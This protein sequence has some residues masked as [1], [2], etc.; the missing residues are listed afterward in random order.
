MEVLKIR[1]MSFDV[2]MTKR[3]I[4]AAI[5]TTFTAFEQIPAR[6]HPQAIVDGVVQPFDQRLSLT[7]QRGGGCGLMHSAIINRLGDTGGAD[8]SQAGGT[9][10][11]VRRRT[12]QDR[13]IIHTPAHA[14]TASR[15]I[16]RR[17]AL[18]AGFTHHM[19]LLK[20][21]AA[22]YRVMV[23]RSSASMVRATFCVTVLIFKLCY[24]CS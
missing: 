16:K 13:R 11:V 9:Q 23:Q 1:R 5:A 18:W 15:T 20:K 17:L 4:A 24:Y 22:R 3:A 7:G 19:G 2:G 21:Q 6:Q 12:A 8:G 14:R 10:T